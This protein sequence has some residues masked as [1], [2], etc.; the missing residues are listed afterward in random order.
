MVDAATQRL[1]MVE[2]QVLTSDVNDRRIL[3]AMRELPRELFVPAP[4]AE[5]AYMDEPVPLTPP[6]PGRRW[7]LAPRAA[8]QAVA[9][10]RIDE[11]DCVLDVGCGT[12]YSS[13]VLAGMAR[14]W[15]RSRATSGWRSEARTNLAGARPRQRR[16]GRRRVDGGWPRQGAVRRHYHAKAPIAARARDAVRSA[17]GRRAARRHRAVRMG[18][19]KA[20]IWRRLGRSVDSWTALRCCHARA[21]RVRAC[22]GVRVSNHLPEERTLP[23]HLQLVPGIRGHFRRVGLLAC[24][25][26]P[27]VGV[28]LQQRHTKRFPPTVHWHYTNQHRVPRLIVDLRFVRWARGKPAWVWLGEVMRTAIQKLCQR[29]WVRHLGSSSASRLDRPHAAR[30]AAGV[31][32]RRPRAGPRGR[33][34][35]RRRSP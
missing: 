22:G 18:L 19:G 12:G 35:R 28:G 9:A 13:A 16:G 7:L 21:P 2:S 10:R 15:S 26:V 11:E 34:C 25:G 17:E 29:K 32:A 23:K 33:R 5:L 8:G 6:G 30:R 20:T 24:G 27:R 31:I 1:N 4:M 3:R 14:R